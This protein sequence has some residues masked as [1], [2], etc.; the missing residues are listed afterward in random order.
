MRHNFLPAKE[1]NAFKRVYHIHVA[2]VALFL[3]SVVVLIGLGSLF[4]VFISVY[5]EERMQLDT[6][7]S[8]KES[9]DTNESTR[10]QK[11]LQVDGARMMILSQITKTVRPSDIIARMIGVRGSVRISS[12]VLNDVSTSTATIVMQGV[13]PTREAL[14]L[15]KTQLEA[16]S[17]GNKVDLPISGFARS[18]DLPFAIK[19]NHILP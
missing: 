4:P 8:L 10:I 15:F 12:I 17:P 6:I 14:V 3:A 9:K 13:A 16:L 1:Q 2:I 19:I 18:R 7:A 5:I 11:E